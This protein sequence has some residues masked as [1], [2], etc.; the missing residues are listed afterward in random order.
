MIVIIIR[1]I[2]E[3]REFSKKVNGCKVGAVYQSCVHS[4]NPFEEDITNEMEIVEIRDGW[5]KYQWRD[6]SGSSEPIERIVR[7]YVKKH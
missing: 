2:K 4:R 3:N 1:H 6:G 7:K 5:A